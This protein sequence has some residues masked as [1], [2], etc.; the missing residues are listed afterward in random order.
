VISV[1]PSSHGRRR[2]SRSLLTKDNVVRGLSY[3]L[4]NYKIG[5]NVIV[6]IDPREHDT[7]P[8]RRFQGKVG[9]VREVG[10]RTLKVSVMIGKKQKILQTRLN[11]IKPLSSIQG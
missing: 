1:M 10:R 7:T 4:I 11:H 8:H 5:E 9:V 3:L 6:D 2:K